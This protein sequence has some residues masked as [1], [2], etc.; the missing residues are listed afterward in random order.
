MQDFSG[1]DCSIPHPRTTRF[2]SHHHYPYPTSTPCTIHAFP[3]PHQTCPITKDIP[4]LTPSSIT[5]FRT[6]YTPPSYHHKSFSPTPPHLYT[7]LILTHT[8]FHTTTHAPYLAVGVL[9][10]N[11]SEDS[12]SGQKLFEDE[13]PGRTHERVA[14]SR[15]RHVIKLPRQDQASA[16]ITTW[17]LTTLPGRL[18]TKPELR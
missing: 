18:I 1:R 16:A 17:A 11:Y 15:G 3:Q 14:P 2:L 7:R 6:M 13:A 4:N 10:G 12:D 8:P 9:A 5:H